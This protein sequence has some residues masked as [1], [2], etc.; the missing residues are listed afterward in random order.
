VCTYNRTKLL[1]IPPHKQRERGRE[2]EREKSN[3]ILALREG[4]DRLEEGGGREIQSLVV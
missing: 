3:N 1:K 4:R 2:G